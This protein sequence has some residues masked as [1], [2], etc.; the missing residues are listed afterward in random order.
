MLQI[1]RELCY[2]RPKK[3][4][5]E[6]KQRLKSGMLHKHEMQDDIISAKHKDLISQSADKHL[7][8]PG[9]MMKF[10]FKNLTTGFFKDMFT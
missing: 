4:E 9:N 7:S 2:Y 1:L 10:V 3:I 8:V 5:I 6:E